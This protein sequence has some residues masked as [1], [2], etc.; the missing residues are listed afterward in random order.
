MRTL[1]KIDYN[2]NNN[3]LFCHRGGLRGKG[4]KFSLQEEVKRAKKMG[5][6]AVEL[7]GGEPTIKKNIINIITEINGQG[8]SVGII[9]NGRMFSYKDFFEKIIKL[10]VDFFFIS[11]H[12]HDYHKHDFLTRTKGSWEQTIRGIENIANHKSKPQ[13]IVNCVVVS[14]NINELEKLVLLLKEKN[15]KRIKFSFPFVKGEIKKNGELIPEPSLAGEKISKALQLCEKNNIEGLYEGLPFCLIKNK[16][17]EKTHNL[18]K[19]QIY[20]VFE[21]IKGILQSTIIKKTHKKTDCLECSYYFRCVNFFLD[22]IPL[23]VQSIYKKI[24]GEIFFCKNKTKPEKHPRSIFVEEKGTYCAENKFFMINDIKSIKERG[25]ICYIK[26]KEKYLLEEKNDVFYETKKSFFPNFQEKNLDIIAGLSGSGMLITDKKKKFKGRVPKNCI[27]TNY[28]SI[29][30]EKF[31]QKNNFFDYVILS[32]S[33]NKIK[34]LKKDLIFF[35]S[36][37]KSKGKLVILEMN[38]SGL[39]REKSTKEKN[40]NYRCHSINEG[41]FFLKELGL[42]V[43]KKEECKNM[44]IITASK[45]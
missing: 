30:E 24:P 4:K 9:S 37:L 5:V 17:R 41:S 44:W 28:K 2:C 13:L 26:N 27:L 11:L 25:S 43:E 23:K 20:Y 18:E 8:M 10:N 39:L 22:N 7:S 29:K 35:V 42:K 3:C 15:V 16:Y 34:Y 1:I 32:E 31:P 38:L 6:A 36:L 19:S 40:T 33:Y 12:S 45:K 21:P 14:E